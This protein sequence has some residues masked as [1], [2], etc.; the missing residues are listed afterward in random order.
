MKEEWGG[1]EELGRGRAGTAAVPRLHACSSATWDTNIAGFPT[2][3]KNE[4]KITLL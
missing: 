2:L 1:D 4:L 3:A